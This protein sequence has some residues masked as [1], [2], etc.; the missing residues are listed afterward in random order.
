MSADVAVAAF[1]VVLAVIGSALA[2]LVTPS[3]S[4]PDPDKGLLEDHPDL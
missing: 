3:I 1:A 4:S 2:L